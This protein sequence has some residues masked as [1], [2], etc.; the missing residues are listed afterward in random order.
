MG[1]DVESLLASGMGCSEP[2][3]GGVVE[4]GVKVFGAGVPLLG[5]GVIAGPPAPG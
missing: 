1:V 5:A 3:G 2:G 4:P